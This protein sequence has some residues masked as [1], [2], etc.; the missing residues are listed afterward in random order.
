MKAHSTYISEKH[1]EEIISW[2]WSYVHFVLKEIKMK[3]EENCAFQ[4][5][6]PNIYIY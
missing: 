3:K 1:K 4:Q 5:N 2:Y 6:F